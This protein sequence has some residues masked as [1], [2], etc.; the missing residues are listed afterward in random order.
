M[1]LKIETI[2]ELRVILKEE[3]GK[4]LEKSDVEKI[5]YSLIGYFDLLLKGHSRGGSEIVNQG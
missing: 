5:A 3:F 2:E 4:E 1:K